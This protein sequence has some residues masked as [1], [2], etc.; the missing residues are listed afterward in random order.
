MIEFDIFGEGKRYA[1]TMSFDDGQ[2]DDKLI[3]IFNRYGIKGTFHLNT[4]SMKDKGLY[5]KIKEVYAG[6]EVSCHGVTHRS[7][8]YI[9]RTGFVNEIF[10]DRRGL[11]AA[12]GYPVVGMS[13]AN[14]VYS[15]PTIEA[16][17]AL[18]IVYS[19]TTKD[20]GNFR[21]PDDFMEWHPT[22]HFKQ[23]LEKGEQF[24]KSMTG[25]FG[26]PKLLYMWG[27]AH[28]L[29][30][31]KEWDKMEEI[32]RLLGNNDKIWYATNIEIYRYIKAQRELVISADETMVYNPSSIPVWFSRNKVDHCIKGGETLYFE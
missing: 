8:D 12:C 23:G 31:R 9:P 3:E 29:E 19:R 25:Y 30:N 1:L 17:R 20:T 7:L 10:E 21:L 14:G 13:Y 15:R 5:D 32:C 2:Y 24:I 26:Y 28:E 22:C 16:L 27:H 4:K 6:H 18:G 11:E